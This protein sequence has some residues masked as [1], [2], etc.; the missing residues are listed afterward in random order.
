[1]SVCGEPC[2]GCPNRAEHHL[3]DACCHDE[4]D[5]LQRKT[6]ELREKLEWQAACTKALMESQERSAAEL[7]EARRYAEERNAEANRLQRYLNMAAQERDEARA[8]VERLRKRVE[9]EGSLELALLE[10]TGR[11]LGKREWESVKDA[12]ERAMSERDDAYDSVAWAYQRGAEAMREAAASLFDA[13]PS[14]PGR[15][16][17]LAWAD[18]I[19]ALPVPEDKP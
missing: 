2:D 15:E 4:V 3:C 8:E 18:S 9:E 19:R 6:R 14:V 13:P 12:A 5:A 1:M 11:A 10:D 16:V 7:K 17:L